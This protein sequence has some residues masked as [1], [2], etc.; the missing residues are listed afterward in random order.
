MVKM[1]VAQKTMF[2]ISDRVAKFFGLSGAPMEHNTTAKS[3]QAF[4][5]KSGHFGMN[6]PGL[7]LIVGTRK[8]AY[9]Y[10]PYLILTHHLTAIIN[11]AKTVKLLQ[12]CC[13]VSKILQ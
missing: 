4:F 8:H 6:G 1:G 9:Y 2:S 3:K 12:N 5:Y 10:M 11:G 7:I 13:I